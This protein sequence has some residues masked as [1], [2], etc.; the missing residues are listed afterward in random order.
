[1]DQKPANSAQA[2]TVENAVQSAVSM[3]RAA[4][5]GG[6]FAPG[7]RLAVARL[8]AEF[9][10]SSMPVREALRHLEGEGIVQI[11]PNRGALVR[12]VDRNFLE[13]LYEVRNALEDLAIARAI[14]RMT[15]A[16]ADLLDRLVEEYVESTKSSDIL[17]ILS[18]LKAF[19]M[20]IFDIA[21]N[22]HASRI[23]ARDWEIVQSLRLT[24]GFRQGRYDAIAVELRQLAKALRNI[25]LPAAR[26][27][28]RLHNSAGLEDLIS[29]E[30]RG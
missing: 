9:G 1:M 14:T 13:N 23:F 27:V 28:L 25:D 5:V 21:D 7:E 3:I 6:R 16:K 11:L 4:L 19:H 8:T 18:R 10:L 30:P 26:S 15:F 2:D 22:S 24:F 29:V 12:P 20:A 17:E